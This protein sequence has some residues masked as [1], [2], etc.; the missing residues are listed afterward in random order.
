[1]AS[2]RKIETTKIGLPKKL[3][4]AAYA[5]VSTDSDEQLLSLKTQKE[6]YTSYI[7]NNPDWEFAGIYADKGIS[8]T[9]L[10]HR[11]NFN[12]MIA[13]C[14]AGK[15]DLIDRVITKSISRFAR[16]TMECLE[17]VRKLM[18]LNISIYFEKENIDTEHMSSELMLSILSSI[19]ESESRSISENS[20]WSIKHRFQEGT[21]IISYPPYGYKNENGQMVIVPEEADVVQDIFKMALNGK[22]CHL[23][24]AELNERGILTKRSGK[25]HA[26]TVQGVL[27]N[28]KYTG[29]VIFQKTYS[30]ENFNRH[31]NYGEE[32]MYLCKNHHAAIISHE[33]F[34]KAADAMTRRGIEKGLNAESDKY[35]N[36]YSFSGKI[37]CG[38]CG[39]TFKRRTHYNPDY[40]AWVCNTHLTSVKDCSMKF[41]E[42]ES[43]KA[44]FVRMIGKL[45]TGG[46][47][48]LKPFIQSLRGYDNKEKL[49]QILALEERIEKNLEQQRVLVELMATGYLEPDVYFSEKRDLELEATSLDKERTA[50]STEINGDLKHLE[51]AQKLLKTVT[52]VKPSAEFDDELFCELVDTVTVLSRDTVTFDL[53]CGLRLKERLVKA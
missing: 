26:S 12:R 20:K 18:R 36:R 43:I 3:Q 50:I 34:E 29:D 37:I 15:I 2:I 25:W 10:R 1:M 48:V 7:K 21:F 28:E 8:G 16:N 40:I 13:D 35:Q 42:D 6:H 51:E 11:D 23:I 52:K 49:H 5:R 32:N 38:E 17:M 44:A 31:R 45:H 33:D 24:A 14:E 41:I 4:V 53:K 19:A 9:S 39:A 30:D 46:T 47:Q 22:G 27:K